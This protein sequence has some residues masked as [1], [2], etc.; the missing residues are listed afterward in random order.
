MLSIADGLIEVPFLSEGV[1]KKTIAS[2]FLEQE[3]Q[4]AYEEQLM[5]EAIESS[6]K[7]TSSPQIN[8]NINK[9]P[10]AQPNKPIQQPQIP[11]PQLN[12]RSNL[13]NFGIREEDIK[14][15]TDLS[16]SREAAIRAL[17]ATGG[18]PEKAAALLFAES[19][20]FF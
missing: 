11:N 8:K 16:F 19:G 7:E 12:S 9:N 20:N 3:E 1:I 10:A 17:R 5:K 2:G 15:L 13:I 6:K 14:K 4:K 18:D